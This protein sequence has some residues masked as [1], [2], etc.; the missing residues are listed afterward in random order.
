[1][2]AGNSLLLQKPSIQAALPVPFFPVALGNRAYE[3]AVAECKSAAALSL[4]LERNQ[5][6]VHVFTTRVLVSDP[7]SDTARYVNRL[8]KF[9]L[10]QIGG[11]K[12]TVAGPAQITSAIRSDFSAQGCQAFDAQLMEQAYGRPFT[13][14][15]VD[16]HDLPSAKEC[17]SSM[18]GHLDGC[19]IGFDLGA[20]D[21]KL[22]AVHDG[23]AVFT[24]E[25][26]WDPRSQPDPEWHFS[27][28]QEGLRL[29]ASHLPR[30]DAI[31][32]SSA[33]IILDNEVRVASLFRSVP[34]SLFQQKARTIFHR[35]RE[36]WKVPFEVANDGDVTALAG[37]MSLGVDA[38][39]GI[40]MG[41]SLA[42]GWR[43]GEG[44]ILGW[45]NE[46]AFVPIDYSPEGPLDEWSGDRGC[47]VQFFSQQAVVRLAGVAGIVLPPGHP[48]EQLKH[49]QELHAKGDE[50]AARIFESIGVYYGYAVAQFANHYPGL[51]HILTLGRVTSGAGGDMILSKAREVLSTEFPELARQ[52]ELHLPDE[53]S[54]RH[55]QAVAAASLP[56]LVRCA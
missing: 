43:D 10:W 12:L 11:W 44:R 30:V 19:R 51:Q 38:I 17:A 8:V 40:A 1:M 32:G 16:A 53:K 47:G 29:A 48:A 50:R 15:I 9:L 27:K 41:S 24:T 14:E 31:G 28:I 18:G 23:R 45:L 25:I 36:A 34:E 39:L 5:G 20:S 56:S 37:G 33:G 7:S 6:L 52:V 49:V 21:Y 22:S 54:K 13:V 2:K 55:G 26:P 3:K 35:I 46:L 42:A 4:A